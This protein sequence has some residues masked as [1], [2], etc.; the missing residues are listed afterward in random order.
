[1]TRKARDALKASIKHWERMLKDPLGGE[2]PYSEFCPLCHQFQGEK[3][4]SELDCKGCPVLSKTGHSYCF[5]TPW[6]N[7]ECAWS[8]LALG[9]TN[10]TGPWEAAATAEIAFLRSLLTPEKKPAAQ[11]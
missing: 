4:S 1:M 8:A 10:N 11:K 6:R 5:R 7:A 3:I 2:R 9:L